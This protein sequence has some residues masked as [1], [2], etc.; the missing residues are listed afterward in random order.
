MATRVLIIDDDATF[1]SL[2]RRILESMGL[3]VMGEAETAEAA[4]A[5]AQELQPDVVLVDVGL[6]DG[7]GVILAGELSR[8][9]WRPR[10]VLTSNDPG[11]VTEAVARSSGAA[12]FIAKQ[13]LPGDSLRELL[14]GHALLE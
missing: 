5:A 6:P 4:V 8:L 9:P 11:A 7:S 12:G 1:R 13:D 3:S 14:I 10:I 2:A